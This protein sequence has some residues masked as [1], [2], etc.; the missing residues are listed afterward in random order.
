MAMALVREPKPEFNFRRSVSQRRSFR[1]CGYEYLLHYGQGWRPKLLKGQYA[2]GNA[3]E[4][5]ATAVAAGWVTTPEQAELGFLAYW[6]QLDPTQ[7]EWSTR[8]TYEKLTDEGVALSRVIVPSIQERILVP[9]EPEQMVAQESIGFELAPGVPELSIPDLW[10]WVRADLFS[11][12]YPTI[13]DFKT[14]DRPFVEQS[15]ELD[16]QLTDY[17][18]AEESQGRYAAQLGLCVMIRGKEPRVQW[19]LVPRR[20]DDVV[21]RF[22]SSAITIDGAIK[23]GEFWQNDRQCFAM[24]T[25]AMVPLC[26][27]SQ[28]SERDNKLV[29]TGIQNQDVFTG[30]DD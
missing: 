26:Y 6:G 12:Y 21:D 28:A 8:V 17:Q 24:G 7:M 29:R 22:R 23:R 13:L 19:L 14:G 2:F 11:D 27:A 18:L 16:E 25:C 5:V 9:E 4:L 30:W 20:A 15:V 10:C 1:R 3:M